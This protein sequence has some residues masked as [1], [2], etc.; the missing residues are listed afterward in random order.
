M[1][2]VMRIERDTPSKIVGVFADKG[3]ADAIASALGVPPLGYG[4]FEVFE[5]PPLERVGR[6]FLIAL[7]EKP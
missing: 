3:K 2:L 7:G 1:Y 4:I 5:M 6:E